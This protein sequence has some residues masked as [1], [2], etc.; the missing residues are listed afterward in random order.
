[1][2]YIVVVVPLVALHH[3]VLRRCSELCLIVVVVPLPPFRFSSCLFHLY[4]EQWSVMNLLCEPCSF[5]TD[6]QTVFG[7]AGLILG[8]NEMCRA[9]CQAGYQLFVFR[10]V[11]MI[12]LM[13]RGQ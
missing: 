6:N 10:I 12:P 9:L 3:R 11:E 4:L 5:P 1:M 13:Q 7:R 8:K 2:C